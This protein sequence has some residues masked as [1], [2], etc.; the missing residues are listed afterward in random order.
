MV[1]GVSLV[2]TAIRAY[3]FNSSGVRVVARLRVG[4]FR[5]MLAQETA[6]FDAA[7]TGDLL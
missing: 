7:E 1:V 5:A 6:W 3:V 2:F 4:L